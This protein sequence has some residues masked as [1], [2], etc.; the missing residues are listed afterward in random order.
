VGYA[1]DA[2]S[3]VEFRQLVEVMVVVRDVEPIEPGTRIDEEV[4][5]GDRQACRPPA[6]RKLD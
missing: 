2:P 3:R 6:I 4:R 1:L 5:Q